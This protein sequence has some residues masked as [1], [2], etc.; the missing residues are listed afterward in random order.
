MNHFLLECSKAFNDV[1]ASISGL[2]LLV[3]HA[4]CE[5]FGFVSFQPV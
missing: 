3:G 1:D 2:G 5:T 4:Q